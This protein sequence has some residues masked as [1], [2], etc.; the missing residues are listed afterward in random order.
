MP[1]D[2]ERAYCSSVR[3]PRETHRPVE[4]ADTKPCKPVDFMA[5][6]PPGPR[7]EES[8][9]SMDY[10]Y[11]YS[12]EFVDYYEDDFAPEY[13]YSYDYGYT[14]KEEGRGSDMSSDWGDD[15]TWMD[16]KE[17]Y[18]DLRTCCEEKECESSVDIHTCW[19]T[20]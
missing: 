11:S 6:P 4:G 15:T 7:R 13:K 10:Y 12:Y 14:G 1:K 5:P 19:H 3:C 18:C 8:S 2:P 17:D 20:L 16:E 9:D